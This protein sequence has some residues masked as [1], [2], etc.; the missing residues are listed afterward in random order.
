MNVTLI[1]L[2]GRNKITART[3]NKQTNGFV[4]L[5]K[6]INLIPFFINSEKNIINDISF[7][8]LLLPKLF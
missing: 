2:F 7:L 4:A 3:S 6:E 5:V 8:K 1:L